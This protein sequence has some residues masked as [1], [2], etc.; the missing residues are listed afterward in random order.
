M[1]VSASL[2]EIFSLTNTALHS[3]KNIQTVRCRTKCSKY[4]HQWECKKCTVPQPIITNYFKEYHTNVILQG[5]I[6]N[7]SVKLTLKKNRNVWCNLAVIL[8][9]FKPSG[10][11]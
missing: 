5:K 2:V 4:E 1:H 9:L 7:K 8:Q 6:N 11:N 10:S 3:K